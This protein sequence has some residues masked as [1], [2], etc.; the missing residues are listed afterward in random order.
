MFDENDICQDCFERSKE[1]SQKRQKETNR[2]EIVVAICSKANTSN[3]GNQSQQFSLCTPF[4]EKNQRKY[5]CEERCG[6]AHNLMKGYCN[7]PER[8]VANDD[9]YRVQHA[10]EKEYY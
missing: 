3:N 7:E 4:I 1:C 6:G 9:V 8:R 5:D 2:C 10:E